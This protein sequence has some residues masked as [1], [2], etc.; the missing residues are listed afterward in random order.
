MLLR[1]HGRSEHDCKGN[2][3]ENKG[4]FRPETETQDEMF[5]K[6]DSQA[7]VFGADEDGRD[8]IAGY[9]KE[10]KAV[11]KMGVVESVENGEED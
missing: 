4:Q 11:V 5:P 7:L 10:E 6:M 2:F 3:E 9:E 1:K 8:D